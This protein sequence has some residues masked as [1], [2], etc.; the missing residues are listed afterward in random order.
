MNKLQ[1]IAQAREG[2]GTAG[3][4]AEGGSNRECPAPPVLIEDRLTPQAW[5]RGLNLNSLLPVYS[6]SYLGIQ[7]GPS[8]RSC[9]FQPPSFVVAKALG[10]ESHWSKSPRGAVPSCR[11]ARN[12]EE[13]P[14]SRRAGAGLAGLTLPKT[15][16]RSDGVLGTF[17]LVTARGSQGSLE[18]LPLSHLSWNFLI[19]GGSVP[20]WLPTVILGEMP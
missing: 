7:L 5:H 17:L 16:A 1:G 11:R 2:W 20:R 10:W 4:G 13:R 14:R 6:T 15:Q 3:T 8:E 9:G 12:T 18:I 19:I